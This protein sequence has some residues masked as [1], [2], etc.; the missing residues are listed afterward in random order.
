MK[1]IILSLVI[2]VILSSCGNSRQTEAIKQAEEIQSSIKPGEIATSPTGYMMTANI[3]GK[4]WEAAS[5]MPP[6]IAG[7][8]VGSFGRQYIGLPYNKTDMALGHKT[9]LGENEAADIYL[10]DNCSYPLTNGEIEITKV[11]G[12][13]VEGKFFFTTVC[14]STKKELK[15]TDG[16][17]RIP[18]A[19]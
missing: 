10:E 16:F 4:R 17:F 11:D 15:V 9:E 6:E 3:D 1:Q 8:I 18:V 2:A 12:K 5:M 14:N 7:R 19:K 13:M